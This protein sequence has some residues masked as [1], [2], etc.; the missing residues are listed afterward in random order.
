M[1]IILNME[2]VSRLRKILLKA[3][4]GP[5][6]MLPLLKEVILSGCLGFVHHVGV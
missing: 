3:Y 4:L 6:E 5:F 1:F 2:I